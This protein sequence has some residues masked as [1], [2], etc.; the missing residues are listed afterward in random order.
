MINAKFYNRPGD[1]YITDW[2]L[3]GILQVNHA[4]DFT[5]PSVDSGW[6]RLT[7]AEK[8]LRAVKPGVA[9]QRKEEAKRGH[10]GT[11]EAQEA[12]GD[13][14]P[15]TER[16]RQQRINFWPVAIEVDGAI[17]PS[18]LRFFKNVCNAAKNLTG[19]NL[20]SFKHYWSK[21]IACELHQFNAKLCLQRA[22]SLRRSFMRLPSTNENVLQFDQLQTD[23][24]SSVSDRSEY[25]D[26]HRTSS[27]ASNARRLLRARRRLT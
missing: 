14:L 22:S 2:T 12:R 5:S 6:S 10:V 8:T 21:R 16:C 26:S 19:Q 9:A 20:S 13:S 25:R 27:N 1:L 4:I 17:T 7:V 18:F 3:E 24:P 15:M 11:A 23:L